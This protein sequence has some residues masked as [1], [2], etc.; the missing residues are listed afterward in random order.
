[1]QKLY[2]SDSFVVVRFDVPA[3][4]AVDGAP[5]VSRGGYEIVDRHARREIFLEGLM[6]EHFKQGVQAL[7]DKNP[8]EE[9]FDEFLSGYC[10]L[11]HQPVTLH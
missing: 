3:A 2:E 5:A 4:G 8:T 6:A 9:A 1:M 10:G 7:V 11:A